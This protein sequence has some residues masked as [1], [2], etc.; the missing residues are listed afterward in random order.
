MPERIKIGEECGGGYEQL[1]ARSYPK[2]SE[3]ELIDG[4]KSESIWIC[5]STLRALKQA[6]TVDRRMPNFCIITPSHTPK[7]NAFSR[8]RFFHFTIAKR[9]FL[10]FLQYLL[11]K[12]VAIEDSKIFT[13]LTSITTPYICSLWRSPIRC[14]RAIGFHMVLLLFA[15][16]TTILSYFSISSHNI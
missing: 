1:H 16:C 10:T 13:S 9:C 15:S 8:C 11:Y 2:S 5:I 4:N 14:I 7:Q 6:T 12:L 3:I